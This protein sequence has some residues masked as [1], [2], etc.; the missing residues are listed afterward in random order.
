M[1]FAIFTVSIISAIAINAFIELLFKTKIDFK[2]SLIFALGVTICLC[3]QDPAHSANLFQA[4]EE[5][6]KTIVS[7]SGND[8]IDTKGITNFFIFVRVIIIL[9]L[10]CLV[11]AAAWVGNQ[12]Q[13]PST[14]IKVFAIA[15]F[16]VLAVQFLS[17]T[18]L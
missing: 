6:T 1:F 18:I 5:A 7:S 10:T 16:S 3:Y 15:L 17:E 13:D 11:V 9:G 2:Y 8:G 4:L 14:L 12:Q